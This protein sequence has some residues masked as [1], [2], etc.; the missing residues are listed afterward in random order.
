MK[1]EEQ[2]AVV[3][4]YGSSGVSAEMEVSLYITWY[5]KRIN[6]HRFAYVRESG[7]VETIRNDHGEERLTRHGMWTE[8]WRHWGRWGMLNCSESGTEADIMFVWCHE[9]VGYEQ[10]LT[11]LMQSLMDNQEDNAL[12][13]AEVSKVHLSKVCID[14]P[15]DFNLSCSNHKYWDKDKDF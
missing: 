1:N 4:D 13:M 10:R 15:Y 2:V 9:K 6:A 5:G 11:K 8:S 14:E 12:D 3:I 7:P